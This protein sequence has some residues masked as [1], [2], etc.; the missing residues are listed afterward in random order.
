MDEYIEIRGVTKRFK[1]NLVLDNLSLKIPKGKLFGVIG[2]NGSGKTTLLNIIIGFLKP[3]KGTVLF[4][5]IDIFSELRDIEAHFG[6]AT[7]ESAFYKHLTV[8]ENL[9][10]YGNLYKIPK[11]EL[12]DR[13]KKILDLVNLSNAKHISANHLS[14][15]MKRRLDIACAL[16]HKPYVLIL[17]EPTED[18]DPLLRIDMLNLIR[19]I[20][21]DGTTVI[22]TSHHLEEVEEYCDIVAILSKAKII[23]IGTP[24]QLELEYSKNMVVEFELASKNYIDFVK[25]IKDKIKIHSIEYENNRVIILTQEAVKLANLVF[26]LAKAHK[27]EIVYLNLNRPSLDLIFKSIIRGEHV[28]GI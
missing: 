27:E 2:E 24:E 28:K 23:K 12:N 4:E 18:L 21:Q 20:K 15:G 1:N 16:I 9:F 22:I 13:V 3:D 14:V 17:D 10:Y 26:D 25:K 6:F 11:K 8:E 7:Q 5:G 19:R